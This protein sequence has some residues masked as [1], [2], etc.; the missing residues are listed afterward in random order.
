M[1]EVH[2][3]DTHEAMGVWVRG[4]SAG[5][6]RGGASVQRGCAETRQECAWW[7]R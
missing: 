2:G 6:K 7:G 4:G 3:G 5:T 1:D